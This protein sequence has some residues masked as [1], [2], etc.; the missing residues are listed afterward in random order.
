MA[1]QLTEGAA[2]RVEDMIGAQSVPDGVV[3]LGV[4]AGGCSGYEYVL[5]IVSGVREN[6]RVFVS[7]GV[8]VVC[9]PRSYLYVN[10]TVV[11]YDDAMM[12]GGFKFENPNATRSCGCGT[13]FQA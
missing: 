9:D 13:S 3:R 1:I 2:V 6:D 12:G 5:D 11:D 4:T 10:G 8:R 7:H